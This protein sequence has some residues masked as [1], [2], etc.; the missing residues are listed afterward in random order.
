MSATANSLQK[1]ESFDGY[2]KKFRV[3]CVMHGV[4]IGSRPDL[5][6]FMK[7]LVEDRHLA[8]D[9][10]GFVGKVSNREGGDLSDD[11]MLALVVEGV[12][13]SEISD[14]DGELKR[15]IDD[16]RAMLAGVDIQGPEQSRI[17]PAPF[18]KSETDSQQRDEEWKTRDVEPSPRPS[19]SRA[20]FTSAAFDEGAEHPATSS[21]TLSPQLDEAL[22]RLELTNL[23]LKQH[24][25]DID[26]KISRLEP[27]LTDIN[28]TGSG[29]HEAIRGL[30]EEPASGAIAEPASKPVSKTRLVLQPAEPPAENSFARKSEVPPAHIPLDDYSQPQG[31][32]RAVSAMLLVLVLAGAG[33]AGYRYRVPLQDEYAGL[34][35]KLHKIQSTPTAAPP[36]QSASSASADTASEDQ[37]PA[38]QP[39]QDQP[40]AQ[41]PALQGTSTP[42]S[43]DAPGVPSARPSNASKLAASTGS[44]ATK[45]SFDSS[46]GHKPISNRT[47]VP[48]EQSPADGIT[49]SE[50]AGSVRV[51]PATMESRLFISRVPA[52]PEVAKINRIQGQVVMQAIISKDGTVKHLHVIQ[53]DSRLRSAALDAVS[54]WRYRPYLL[55][56]QPVDVATT[57]KVDFNL[58]R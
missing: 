37:P 22:L 42:P 29:S 31:Y 50:L 6:G 11:Q 19:G 51:D 54:K 24:L 53:G 48:A 16:L 34:L 12:T 15:P 56:G 18:P 43:P 3:I 20:A 32:G 21:P 10:W 27:H 40:P 47:A 38:D 8:M 5:P 17:E 57:V 7:K 30:A 23:E 36:N 4:Q 52:Y 28:S 39:K 45:G 58:D 55:S 49:S 25:D 9:F 44:Q 26:Q 46:S 1:P 35:Q 2:V 33:F 13:S 41:Q 14:E